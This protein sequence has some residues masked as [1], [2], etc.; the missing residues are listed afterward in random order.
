M[1]KKKKT[2]GRK[3][4]LTVYTSPLF[5]VPQYLADDLLPV[6]IDAVVVPHDT[7]VW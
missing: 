7:G 2:K 4:S 1:R 3:L 6:L 5:V